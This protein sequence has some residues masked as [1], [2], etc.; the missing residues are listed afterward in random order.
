MKKKEILFFENIQFSR[1]KKSRI[2]EGYEIISIT[3]Y[4]QNFENVSEIDECTEIV[5]ITSLGSINDLQYNA[6]RLFPFF[7]SSV[8]FIAN[9]KYKELF[10]HELRYCFEEFNDIEYTNEESAVNN[11]FTVIGSDKDKF[12]HRKITD[13]SEEE[14][15]EFCNLFS[16]QLYG[17]EKF[18]DDFSELLRNFRIFNK[19]GEHKILSLFL[20]GDSGVGKTEVARAIHK[21]LG[22]KKKLAKINF[23]NYSSDN[24]LNSLIGSPRGYI[25]SEEGEIF[26]RVKNSDVGLILIDE[27]EKSNSTL[28]NYFL[29]VLENGKMVS[30]LA[31]EIDLNG[32]I[33]IFTSNINK[34]N[35]VQAISPEL[36]SRFDY[37]GYFTLLYS[38]DK[39]KFVEFRINSI[40][41]KFNKN[42]PTHLTNEIKEVL[43]QQIDVDKFSNMRDLNNEI[44]RKFVDYI[45]AKATLLRTITD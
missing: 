30:S 34:E 5:D 19:I 44:K 37:K 20:M 18:K 35:F 4:L 13:L 32:F 27:F 40:I 22:G 29:D 10:S 12:S 6:E 11:Q 42:F 9:K 28:F 43:A 25:G 3:K 41:Y 14:I 24:S 23:G 45:A 31:E 15:I 33:I 2:D 8:I 7:S 16:K 39:L 26:I 17:H 36:R 38:K 21:C 1:Y